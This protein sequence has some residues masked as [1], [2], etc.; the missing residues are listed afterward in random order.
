MMRKH[1]VGVSGGQV[2][3][4]LRGARLEQDWPPLRSASDIER[5]F[6]RKVL[7]LVVQ[8]MQLGRIEED[9][10]GTVT[11]E[12]IVLPRIPQ[13]LGDFEVLSGNAIA[14]AMLWMRFFGEVACRALQW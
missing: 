9:T 5:T 1:G 12:R 7:A 14:F 3:A 4:I 2:L 10:A 6:H 13:A 8:R 11:Y